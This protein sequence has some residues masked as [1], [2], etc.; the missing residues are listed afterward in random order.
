MKINNLIFKGK[1]FDFLSNS[2]NYSL[3]RR[4]EI[5]M[6]SVSVNIRAFN[7]KGGKGFG[8]LHFSHLFTKL[9]NNLPLILTTL[10]GIACEQQTHFRSSLGGRE[11]TTGNASAVHRLWMVGT[12]LISDPP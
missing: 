4:K 3:R 12:S 10:D 1:G 2:V 11:V 9:I 6:E 5:R 8:V 7:S